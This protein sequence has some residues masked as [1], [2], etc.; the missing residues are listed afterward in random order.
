MLTSHYIFFARLFDRQT[1]MRKVSYQVA[2]EIVY[3][4]VDKF[5]RQSKRMTCCYTR[6]SFFISYFFFCDMRVNGV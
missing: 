4:G 1:H 3:L 2:H 5:V 6:F